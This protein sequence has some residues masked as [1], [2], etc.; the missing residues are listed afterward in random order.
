MT[1]NYGGRGHNV[2]AT[3]WLVANPLKGWPRPRST[4]TEPSRDTLARWHR[5]TQRG[6]A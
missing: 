2:A 4:A 1:V 5:P 6:S 3:V